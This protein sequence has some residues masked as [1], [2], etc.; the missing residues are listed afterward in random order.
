MD[1]D[2]HLAAEKKAA[3]AKREEFDGELETLRAKAA[4]PI[5]EIQEKMSA[6][7]KF[8]DSFVQEQAL[9]TLMPSTNW[10]KL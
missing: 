1:L 7:Q 4:A 8:L 2:S 10:L 3:T 6:S 9:P 5:A